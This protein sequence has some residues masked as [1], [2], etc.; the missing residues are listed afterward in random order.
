MGIRK[1]CETCLPQCT[2][3]QVLTTPDSWHSHRHCSLWWVW[4]PS[5][6]HWQLDP[7]HLCLLWVFWLSL[8]LLVKPWVLETEEKLCDSS[9]S[10]LD[11]R[12]LSCALLYTRRSLVLQAEACLKVI[13]YPKHFHKVL[14]TAVQVTNYIFNFLK[15]LKADFLIH[16]IES[17]L[18]L[19]G[20]PRTVVLW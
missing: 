3:Q 6:E 11:E 18:A 13:W 2:L 9:R 8:E 7:A 10:H 17:S 20:S 5:H 19:V 1:H 12:W 16:V 4:A 14:E 15:K